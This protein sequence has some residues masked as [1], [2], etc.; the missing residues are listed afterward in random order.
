MPRLLLALFLLGCGARTG[1]P[2]GE[3]DGGASSD[4]GSG[5][6]GGAT[7]GGGDGAS[8]VGGGGGAILTNGCADGTREGFIDELSF[9]DIA[10]CSGGFTVPG[11]LVDL[12]AT[13]GGNAGNDSPNPSGD[14][15]SAADLCSAGFVVC[16]TEADVAARSPTGCGSITDAPDT[17]FITRQTGTGCGKCAFGSSFDPSCEQCICAD[18]CAPSNTIAN[19]VFGCGTAGDLAL[20]CGVIDRFSNDQCSL[21]PLPWTCAGNGCGEALTVSKPGPG[22]GGALCCRDGAG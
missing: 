10:G 19:D 1:L 20:G 9:P 22:G 6:N 3:R 8:N 13:C 5:G 18:N 11:V 15:C 2:I 17:F 12:T 16:Q 14:G 7:G 21:L 4:G